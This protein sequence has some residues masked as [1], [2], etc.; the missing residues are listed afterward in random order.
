MILFWAIVLVILSVLAGL[1]VLQLI[2]GGA[3]VG[4]GP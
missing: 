4:P 2:R 1:G 3:A